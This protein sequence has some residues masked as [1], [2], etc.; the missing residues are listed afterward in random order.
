[1]FRYKLENCLENA[2]LVIMHYLIIMMM[3]LQMWLILFS[4]LKE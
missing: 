4:F 1:M 3:L 2:G